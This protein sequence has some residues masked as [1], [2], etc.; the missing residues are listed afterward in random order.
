MRNLVVFAVVAST[1]SCV[2]GAAS[3]AVLPPSIHR[4]PAGA[5]TEAEQPG[6]PSA[7]P[8][9]EGMQTDVDL[10]SGFRD[11]YGLGVEA[12]LGYATSN[13]AYFGGAV[14]YFAGNTVNA[15][16]AHATFLGAEAAYK[17][18][19]TTDKRWEIR[20]YV[21]GGPA[22][23]TTVTPYPLT[24]ISRTALAL[25]PGLVG[26]YH[27]GNGFLQIDARYFVT[28]APTTVAVFGGAG[29]AF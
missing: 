9:R 14:Q 11:T 2:A 21:F 1:L 4:P 16:S 19:P 8:V 6:A 27:F 10:G 26:A 24:T 20:P 7:G 13:G 5:G 18:F 12:R 23:V 28:P 15:E 25:Q 3:A 22:F 17:I 29:L